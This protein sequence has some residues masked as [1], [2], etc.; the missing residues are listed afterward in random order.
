MKCIFSLLICALFAIGAT[1]QQALA[2]TQ[3]VLHIATALNHLTVLEFHEP[4]T[5]A[6]AGS[7]D[8]QIERQDSRVFVKP[9]KAGISTDLLVWTAS[10]RFAYE[11]E[12]TEEVKT[13]NVAIDAA[14]PN[15]PPSISTSTDDPADLILT[16]AFLGAVQIRGNERAQHD[17]LLVRVEQVFRSRTT[18]Y[19]H[20]K[21]ENNTE[22]AFHVGSPAVFEL[23]PQR[24]AVSLGSIAH[25]QLDAGLIKKLGMS[26]ALPL[27]LARY[28]SE[29]ESISPGT[30]SQGVIAIRHDL[31][32]PAVLQIVFDSGVKAIF[33]L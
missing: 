31:K 9:T 22:A 26:N 29:T 16:R 6:A 18:V 33:V 13:M 7:S 17:R 10:R 24:S 20:Y 28:E 4:V 8:F 21:I 14:V 12:T 19:I 32:S 1:A 11:L 15:P 5:M 23:K 27:P 25:T 2:P 30:T 3:S